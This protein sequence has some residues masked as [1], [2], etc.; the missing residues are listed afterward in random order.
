MLGK[1]GSLEIPVTGD[2]DTGGRIGARRVCIA[3]G[4]TPA[5]MIHTHHTVFAQIGTTKDGARALVIGCAFRIKSKTDGLAFAGSDDP[6]TREGGPPAVAEVLGAH[7]F[8]LGRE[9]TGCNHKVA[10]RSHGISA[11]AVSHGK[12]V[13]I[14]AGHCVI[15]HLVFR[16]ADSAV[17]RGDGEGGTAGI[18]TFNRNGRRG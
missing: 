3:R 9:G 6:V 10:S 13:G 7:I 14:R 16:E 2:I 12:S 17:G 1:V 18:D 5:P 15:H 4:G 11:A 8:F